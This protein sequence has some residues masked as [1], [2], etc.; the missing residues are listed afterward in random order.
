MSDRRRSDG[1][2]IEAIQQN[3]I[4]VVLATSGD[5]SVGAQTT[6]SASMSTSMTS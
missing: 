6:S 3:D 1:Y 5:F 4:N 2:T